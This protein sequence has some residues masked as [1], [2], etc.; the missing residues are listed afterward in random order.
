LHP[1]AA[2]T[3]ARRSAWRAN[4]ALTAVSVVLALLL[5]EVLLRMVGYDRPQFYM[6][7]PVVGWRPR[8]G[9][10]GW[11]SRETEAYGVINR[12]GYRDIGHPLEKP[13]D[14]YRIVLLGDSMSE[15]LETGFEDLYWRRLEPLLAGCPALD[16]RRVEV[17]SFAVNGYGT[18]QEYLT[19]QQRGLKYRPDLVLLAFFSG[20][21]FT[22]DVEA[23]GRHR[24]RPYFSLDNGRL[25][26][27]Q[28]AGEAADFAARRRHEELRHRFLDHIRLVQLAREASFHLG[29]L[30]RYGRA[31]ASRIEQPGLDSR[32]FLPPATPEWKEA[33]AVAEALITAISDAAQRDGA[34]FALTTLVNPL[35]DLPDVAARDRL[36]RGI[37]AADLGYPDRRLAQFAADHGFPDIALA[38]PLA[39]YAAE[40]HAALHG[41]ERNP[42]G[43]WN[44]LGHRIAAQALSRGLCDALTAGKL[45]PPSARAQSGSNTLR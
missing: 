12:E 7:D 14:A 1:A 37:G 34:A 29:Q 17:I 13:A 24:D 11:Y 5:A 36:A 21:D 39:D 30:L 38:A 31:D 4:I 43:H 6:L 27:R 44:A 2:G 15:S 19:L 3:A 28:T 41:T 45:P 22:D 26:L 18:A 16:G 9:V 40:H 35:Q 25:V 32:V 42:V 20:N 33:W 23:L 10:A 8:P